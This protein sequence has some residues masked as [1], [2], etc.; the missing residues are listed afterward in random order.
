MFDEY[1]LRYMFEYLR[2]CKKCN[3][4]D[5]DNKGKRCSICNDYFCEE[6]K[7]TFV[8]HYELYKNKHCL[9]CNDYFFIS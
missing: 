5:L 6:C 4:F 3:R 1:L 7:E 8:N 9:Y 2:R